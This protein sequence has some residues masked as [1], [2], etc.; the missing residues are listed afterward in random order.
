MIRISVIFVVIMIFAFKAQSSEVYI[1][2]K[3]QEIKVSPGTFTFEEGQVG[4]HL[5]NPYSERLQMA[6][7]D[8]QNEILDKTGFK[9]SLNNEKELNIIVGIPEKNKD[10]L[11][12]VTSTG[13]WPEER[14]KS[15]GYVLSIDSSEILIIAT[16]EADFL[17]KNSCITSPSDLPCAGNT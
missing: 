12:K 9:T 16:H 13:I 7:I 17:F 11:N 6:I 8:L 15:E 2:P 10:L 5:L 3:P 14:I 1:V 4:I